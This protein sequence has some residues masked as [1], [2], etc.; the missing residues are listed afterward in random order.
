V[1]YLARIS[2][3]ESPR[4]SLD[5]ARERPKPR[6]DRTPVFLLVAVTVFLHKVCALTAYPNELKCPLFILI[7]QVTFLTGLT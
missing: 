3:R 5:S 6:D 7:F 1:P 4:E 2:P